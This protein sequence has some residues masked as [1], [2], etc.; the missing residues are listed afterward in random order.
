MAIADKLQT[1]AENEQKVY[2]AGARK[3]KELFTKLADG[4]ITDVTADDLAGVTELRRNAFSY[5]SIKNIELPNTLITIGQSSFGYCQGIRS[6]EIP[7]S[8]QTIGESVFNG[9]WQI[10]TITIGAGV[11]SI[12]NYAFN[13]SSNAVYTIRATTPPTIQPST[14]YAS[15]NPT[16]YVPQGCAEAYKTATNWAQF[17]DMIYE[18]G[19]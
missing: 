18:V 17:A 11:K 7:D 9:S 14:F 15:A 3:G 12:G 4:S 16:F 5:S 13:I 8:V 19:A 10:K 6:I 2:E 1:I